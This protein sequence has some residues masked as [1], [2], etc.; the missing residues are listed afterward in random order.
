[1]NRLRVALVVLL[2]GLA[3]GGQGSAQ[4]LPL[5]IFERYLDAL[6]IEAAIPGLS[7]AIVQNGVVVWDRGFGRQDVEANVAARSDTPYVI[8]DLSQTLGA[9]LTL[10]VCVDD[11]Y[12]EI[13]DVVRRWYPQYPEPTTTLE[14]LL[15]HRSPSR[16]FQYAPERF[17]ALTP[18]AEECADVPY[19]RLLDERVFQR[20]GMIDSVPGHA[21]VAPTADDV[22][23]LGAERLAR[24]AAVLSRL[25]V[26]YRVDANGRASR[27]TVTPRAAD[28]SSGL[29]ST[30]LDLAKFDRALDDAGVLLSAE[31]RDRSWTPVSG[32]PTGLGWFVQTY[33][34]ERIVWHFGLV[35]DAY[36]SLI[37]KVPGRGLTLILLAN[38]DRLS[39]PFALENGDIRPSLFA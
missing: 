33:N 16:A 24:Y 2:A 18:V 30:V 27:S 7:A 10:K 39:A 31:L 6:R 3:V 5:S 21:L 20:L 1:M 35:R 34:G 38:S 17:A 36:S 12:A 9:T 23:I 37:V 29:V 28:T 19:R 15:A 32:L 22:A 8:G 26:P 25:A 13:E 14:D 11:S 4:V